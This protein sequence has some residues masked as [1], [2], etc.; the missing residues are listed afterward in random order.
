MLYLIRYPEIGSEPHQNKSKI[1]N[2]LLL[3][4]RSRLSGTKCETGTGR[5]Y[6]T[7]ADPAAEKVLSGMHGLTSFSPALHCAL[8]E[9]ENI[10]L[11][12]SLPLLKDKKKFAVKVR[13]TGEHERSSQEIASRLGSLVKKRLPGIKVDFKRPE[14]MIFV[15]IRNNDCFLFNRIV[16]GIDLAAAPSRPER[17][18]LKE[19]RFIADDM[20]GKLARRLRMLGY[21]VLYPKT[22]ADSMLVRMAKDEGRIILTRDL[23]LSLIRGVNAVLLRSIRLEDQLK[24]LFGALELEP[25]RGRMF[26][27]CAVDNALLVSIEK[28]AVK[29]RVPPL[30]YSIFDNFTYCPVCDRVYWKGT[31]Y[32]RMLTELG[33]LI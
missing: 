21:D 32:E 28:E 15:E 5:I 3:Q 31:H 11:N 27:R 33:D 18:K 10:F 9:L 13:R 24:E 17:K 25:E 20:L 12:F 19:P 16:P 29:P 6:L 2:D 14:G 22:S 4:I 30:V 7:T 1:R 26:S 23:G 8:P